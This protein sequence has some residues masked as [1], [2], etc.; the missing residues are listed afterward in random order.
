MTVVD[1]AVPPAH[2]W[3]PDHTTTGAAQDAA[4]LAGQLGFTLDPE[5]RYALEVILAERDGR[6]ASL[7]ACVICARQNLKT[8]LFKIIALHELFVI[9]SRLV[10]W[11]AHEF[12]TAME[13]FRDMREV[14]DSAEWL[15]RRVK[16]VNEANGKEGIEFTTGQRIRFKARTKS[17][18]RG[19]TGDVVFLD[20]AFALQPHHVGSLLPTMAARS[21][22]GNPRIYYGSSAGQLQSEVLRRLRDRGRP[23]GDPSLAYIEWCA[24]LGCAE[25]DCTHIVGSVGCALD[26][27]EK[28]RMANPA[29]ERR[30]SI[31]FVQAMRRSLPPDEFAREFLGWWEDPI[32]GTSGIPAEAW[33]ACAERDAELTEPVTLAVDA[34]PGHASG[35]VVA[36]GGPLH[37]V[38]H[39]RG[40]SWII[41][42]VRQIIDGT[43][44][45]PAKNVVAVGIDP[46]G[47]AAALIPDFEKAGITVRNQ[48]NPAGLL[49]L[50]DGREAIQACEAFLSGVLD[51][52]VVHRD[53]N[54][55]NTAVAGAGRRQVGDS[56]KWSRRDSTVDI[57]PLVAATIAKHLWETVNPTEEQPLFA[58]WE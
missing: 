15:R 26:D 42:S 56:W 13:A 2:V 43:P 46:T 6:W 51:G 45:R 3:V 58:M 39:G 55:L 52:T 18:G 8:F 37:V 38:E 47:P 40:T 16:S 31:E 54:T 35:S 36:C 44:T 20:E 11:T 23:G 1:L 24:P 27:I 14:I 10:V 48:K 50:L 7:E 34:S 30:I 17:G 5:Q 41:D 33:E 28:V 12:N 29:L 22:T 57:S 53:Q 32:A 19:L 4:D 9:G 25:P 21:K 49:V